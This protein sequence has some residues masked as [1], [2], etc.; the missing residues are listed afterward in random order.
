M[1][2]TQ[3]GR[4]GHRGTARPM[5]REEPAGEPARLRAHSLSLALDLRV[6]SLRA[7]GPKPEFLGAEVFR[8]GL[9]Q[10]GSAKTHPVGGGVRGGE[11]DFAPASVQDTPHED[12]QPPIE[13]GAP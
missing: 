12:P 13:G 1:L 6:A 5:K 9:D 4:E 2:E 8:T 11:P 3:R 10:V 7:S